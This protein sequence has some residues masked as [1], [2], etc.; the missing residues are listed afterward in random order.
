MS[1]EA[2]QLFTSILQAVR[3]DTFKDLTLFAQS[4]RG[5]TVGGDVRGDTEPTRQTIKELTW[6]CGFT[7]V[8]QGIAKAEILLKTSCVRAHQAWPSYY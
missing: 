4:P 2:W 5:V 1:E 3:H 7:D 8:A 6:Q